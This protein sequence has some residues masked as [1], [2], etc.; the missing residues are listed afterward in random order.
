MRLLPFGEYLPLQGRF[1]WPRWLVPRTGNFMAGTIPTIFTLPKGRFG[2]VICWENLFPDFFRTFVIAGA[3]F[4]V[5]PTNEAWFAPAASQQ[6]LAMAVLR[7]VE[8][9]VPLLRVANTGITSYIDPLGRIQERVRDDTGKDINVAGSLTVTVQAPMG[10]TYYTRYGDVFARTCAGVSVL[11]LLGAILPVR[12]R[13]H[14]SVLEPPHTI[15]V[16]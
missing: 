5:N 12:M 1:P 3:Q 15:R 13:R 7:A 14:A 8:H 10:P 9:R 6:F 2:T 4:M 16:I 11:F